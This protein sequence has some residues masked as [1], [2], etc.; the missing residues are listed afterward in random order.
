MMT[1]EEYMDVM[2]M[3]RQGLTIKEIAA[4]TG[5]H[6]KTISSWLT[7]GGPPEK[8]KKTEPMVIDERWE[9]RIAELLRLAPRLLGTSVFEMIA[10]EGYSGSYASVSRHLNT[11]RGPRFN[12][13]P[14]ASTATTTRRPDNS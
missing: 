2:A 8:R 10:A 6:P 12:G 9:G 5:Y 4:D 1:Q 3:K 13:A 14:L 11:I 7:N